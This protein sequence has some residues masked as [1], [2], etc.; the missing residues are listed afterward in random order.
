MKKILVTTD[1]SANSKAAIRFAIQ[2]A[3]QSDVALTFFYVLNVVRPTGWNESTYR[4]YEKKERDKALAGL[5][6][7]INDIYKDMKVS[8]SAHSSV[9]EISPIADNVI[10]GYAAD[11]AFDFICISTRGAGVLEKLIGTTVANLINQ[12]SVPVIAVPETYRRAKLTSL[13]YA[14]DLTCLKREIPQ[15]ADFAKPLAARVDMIHFSSPS[16]QVTD[17]EIINMAVQ[18]FSDYPIEVHIKPLDLSKSLINNIQ[19]AI[20][21]MKP[22]M[23][24]L[25]TT[26]NQGFFH[27]LFLSGNAVN[28]AFLTTVPLL[29]FA[30]SKS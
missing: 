16:E 22:S 27:Q 12:S 25:F 3:S 15:V 9:V 8:P 11:K 5:D 13:L 6:D 17:P 14:S 4:T 1:F 19:S 10:M 18:K 20:K 24:I 29:V 23:V 2:L 30:K 28:Y 7:L 21:T 26:Q